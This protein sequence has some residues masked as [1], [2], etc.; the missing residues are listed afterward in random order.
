MV[1]HRM[2]HHR[3]SAYL[4]VIPD[5]DVAKDLCARPHH[6]AIAQRGMALAPLAAGTAQRDTLVKQHVVADLRS[7]ADHH[8]RA[9][10]DE[11][12]PPDRGARMNLDSLKET[13]DLRKH[14]R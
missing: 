10:I 9:V 12:T 6:Y 14:P 13:A 7:L 1:G 4:H 8:A 5:V 3:A 2:H 11:E